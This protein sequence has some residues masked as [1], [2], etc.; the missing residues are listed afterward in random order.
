LERDIYEAWVTAMK[1]AQQVHGVCQV[2]GQVRSG[3][4]EQTIQVRMTY[5]PLTR[6]AGKLRFGNANRLLIDRPADRHSSPLLE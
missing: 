3:S 1:A 6:D 5:T 2:A 4:F